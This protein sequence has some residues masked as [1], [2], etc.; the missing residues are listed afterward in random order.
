M[1]LCSLFRQPA[2]MQ[3]TLLIPYLQ[4]APLHATCPSTCNLRPCT[5]PAPYAPR[6]ATCAHAHKD[7]TPA[8]SLATCVHAHKDAT[9]VPP[10]ATCAHALAL[11]DEGGLLPALQVNIITASVKHMS[12]CSHM[13]SGCVC[14][15]PSS[16]T[17]A[18]VSSRA[19]FPCKKDYCFPYIGRNIY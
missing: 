4:P 14:G 15:C 2:P 3:L 9:P 8:P 7:A 1:V 18:S 5:Q 19:T 16:V 6:L 10:L 11:Q 17:P 13:Y 12:C